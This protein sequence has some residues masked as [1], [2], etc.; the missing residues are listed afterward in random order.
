MLAI[1]HKYL[2]G[3]SKAF[4]KLKAYSAVNVNNY[5]IRKLTSVGVSCFYKTKQQP[6]L[7]AP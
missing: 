3:Y 5:R 6:T 2:G 4:L 1:H 7:N